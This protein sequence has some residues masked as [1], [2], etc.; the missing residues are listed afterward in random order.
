MIKFVI[1]FYCDKVLFITIIS[2][3]SNIIVTGNIFCNIII[4]QSLEIFLKDNP[5]IFINFTI[6]KLKLWGFS[7][8]V[9]LSKS[10]LIRLSRTRPTIYPINI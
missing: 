7:T 9:Y 2:N 5:C 6:S 8:T 4:S 3:I 10:L 1:T